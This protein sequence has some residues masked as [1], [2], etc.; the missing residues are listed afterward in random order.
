MGKLGD[1]EVETSSGL[2]VLAEDDLA[3]APWMWRALGELGVREGQGPKEAGGVTPDVVKYL[4][5]CSNLDKKPSQ[6]KDCT[7]WCSAFVNWCFLQEGYKGTDNAMAM[8]WAKWP[9][10]TRLVTPRLGAVVVFPNHVGFFCFRKGEAD[11]LLGGNQPERGGATHQFSAP[12]PGCKQDKHDCV[13]IEPYPAKQV[14]RYMWPS[15]QKV[16]SSQ[17][18]RKAG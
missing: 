11:Y 18:A 13:C 9:L 12:E 16:K 3:K 14:V 2:V 8:S 7:S 1:F 4:K 5:T 15:Q 17:K 6:N 10:G